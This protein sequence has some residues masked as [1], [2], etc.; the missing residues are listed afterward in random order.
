MKQKRRFKKLIIIVIAI[1]LIGGIGYWY[2]SDNSNKTQITTVAVSKATLTDK[3]T[4]VGSIMPAKTTTVKSVIPGTVAELFHQ[5]GDYVNK[6]DKLAAIKPQP[7]PSD[8]A[9]AKQLVAQDLTKERKDAADVARYEYLLK[10]G[11][12][13]PK[14]QDLAKAR[15]QYQY[16]HLQRLL[17]QEKLS[18]LEKG[19]ATIAGRQIA[20]VITSPTNGFIV[21][22][23]VNLGDPVTPQTDYQSGSVLFVVA[24]MRDMI[25]KGQVSEIDAAKLTDGMSANVLIAP[26]PKLKLSGKLT[27]LGL[28]SVQANTQEN[29]STQQASQTTTSP[30]NVGFNVQ[31][32][33]LQLPK[34]IKL[35][36]GYSATATISVKEVKN[37]LSLP[38]SSIQFNAA[39]KPYVWLPK[40]NGKPVKHDVTVGI[41]DGMKVQIISGLKDGEKVLTSP[42]K[43][44]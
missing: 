6:G 7:T 36:A 29:P 41:S 2:K 21:A 32:E 34:N 35:R 43:D 15:Q 4:A 18:L 10:Q 26:L 42:P 12:I 38:E 27:K 28:E 22:R 9:A 17:D 24:D 11:A 23:E 44:K 20:N 30:F 31:I 19:T 39:G 5:E 25:F 8:Y 33:D 1:A 37:A 14:D 13:S 16:D 40:K 3:V